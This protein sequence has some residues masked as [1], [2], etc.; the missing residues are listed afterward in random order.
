MSFSLREEC[1]YTDNRA[2]DWERECVCMCVYLRP[3]VGVCYC[4]CVGGGGHCDQN[5]PEMR[6]RLCASYLFYGGD[7]DNKE[8]GQAAGDRAGGGVD[9][10]LQRGRETVGGRCR[11]EDERGTTERRGC[12]VTQHWVRKCRAGWKASVMRNQAEIW[13]RKV[14]R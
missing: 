3:G 12:Q 10:K 2:A 5:Y 9:D 14:P 8:E 13:Q 7:S 1:V 4:V 6:A 11:G